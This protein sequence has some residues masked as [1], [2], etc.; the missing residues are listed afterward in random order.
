MDSAKML[1]MMLALIYVLKLMW[2]ILGS[3]LILKCFSSVIFF[4]IS[5]VSEARDLVLLIH[6]FVTSQAAYHKTSKHEATCCKK[7]PYTTK[8]RCWAVKQH[9]LPWARPLHP[10]CTSVWLFADS[11]SRSLCWFVNLHCLCK[12]ASILS[13]SFFLFTRPSASQEKSVL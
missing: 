4:P 2:K 3:S 6:T 11:H 1:S 7:P 12:T 8:G 10:P 13:F 5:I 9:K